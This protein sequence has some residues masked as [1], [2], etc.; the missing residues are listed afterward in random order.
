MKI[1]Q[2]Y[3]YNSKLAVK[4]K[5]FTPQSGVVLRDGLFKTVFDNNREFLKKLDMGKMMY[6]FDKKTGTITTSEPYK[7]HFEDN[8]KGSTLS[9]F[10]MG[11]ANALRWCD[12]EELRSR[13]QTAMD[14]LKSAAEPDGFAMPI[15]KIDFPSKEYPHYTRIWLTYALCAVGLSCGEGAYEFLRNWQDWFNSCQDLPVIKY[16]CLAFQGVVAST[17]EYINTPVGVTEDIDTTVRYYEE[18]WRLGQFMRR[19]KDA[20]HIRRQHGDE[21]HAHGSELEGFEG[22]LDLYRVT[23]KSYYLT[24]VLGAWELYNRDWEHAG[25]GIVMCEGMPTNYPGCYWLDPKNNY[26]ELCCTS[27]WLYLNLRLH[28]L[29]PDEEKY[30]SEIEKSLLNIAIAN[31]DG[32]DGIRYFAYLDDKKQESG[33]VHCCCGVGTRIFGSLP[34]LIYSVNDS[35]ISVDLYTPSK[36]KWERSEGDVTVEMDADVPYSD[37]VRLKFGMAAP[38]EFTVRLRIPSWAT[39]EVKV[40]I[41][42][43]LAATGVPG[44]YLV[45]KRLF[46][47]GDE[48]NYSL[49]QSFRLTRYRGADEIAGF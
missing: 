20:V 21:P 48:I 49:K 24:A 6:W 5:L 25:G 7:G 14:R 1:P 17:Y 45:I 22:Y 43:E 29:F 40:Y 34:E 26:N 31:Q 19:E 37:D 33:L 13:V 47:D 35:E 36:I 27:F 2:I 41:N 44:T 23:G 4:D 39:E 11:A 42:G 16:L 9:M 12:D 30:V 3:D 18:P 15:S 38:S 8:L 10:M 46:S 28:R 32:G